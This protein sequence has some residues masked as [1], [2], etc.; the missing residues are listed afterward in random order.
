MKEKFLE[1]F[2]DKVKDFG[3]SDKAIAALAE[4]G[5]EGFNDDTTEEDVTKQVD[6]MVRIAKSMQGEVTR[7]TQ[8]TKD[9]KDSTKDTKDSK[10]DKGGDDDDGT[11]AWFS[12]FQSKQTEAI[13]ALKAE[14]AEMKTAKSKAD[15]EALIASKAKEMGIPA[16]L[17]KHVTIGEDEDI[18]E[19]LTT[20]KQELVNDK[21]LPDKGGEQGSDDSAMAQAAE[22]WAKSLP[23]KES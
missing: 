1:Q 8:R 17:I 2:K 23:D 9:S 5:C 6:F 13:D 20:L 22:E 21:L 3:L 12:K 18:E 10:D 11:P 16:G 15:R 19:T 14:L 7:K 4:Q